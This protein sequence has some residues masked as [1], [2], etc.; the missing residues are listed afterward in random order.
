MSSDHFKNRYG[1]WAVVTGASDGIGR[2]CARELAARGLSLVLVARR[3]RHLEALASELRESHDG[4][5]IRVISADLGSPEGVA[6][7]VDGTRDLDVG[8][9]EE[10]STYLTKASQ[11]FA[12]ID[13]AYTLKG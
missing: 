2:A 13:N 3:R 10:M 7:V 5:K 1:P 9:L 12:D 6:S 4:A 8:L 11:A